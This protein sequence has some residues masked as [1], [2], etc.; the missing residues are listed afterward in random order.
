MR[1]GIF[2]EVIGGRMLIRRRSRQP[3]TTTG[4]EEEVRE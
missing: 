2:F 3:D 4:T 1:L